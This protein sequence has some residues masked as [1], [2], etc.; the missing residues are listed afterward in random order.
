MQLRPSMITHSLPYYEQAIG[1]HSVSRLHLH[2]SYS[3]LFYAD[4]D[5]QNPV[6]CEETLF[7]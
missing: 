2:E 6:F 1:L 3:M 4:S 5:P 7:G